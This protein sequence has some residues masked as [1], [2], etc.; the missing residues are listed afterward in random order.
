M[1]D[2]VNE[3][4][5]KNS[6]DIKRS[7]LN[8]VEKDDV[9]SL[10]E[11]LKLSADVNVANFQGRTPLFYANSPE[12]AELLIEAGADVTDQAHNMIVRAI[13]GDHKLE[14]TDVDAISASRDAVV[15]TLVVYNRYIGIGES[16]HQT[17]FCSSIEPDVIELHTQFESLSGLDKSIHVLVVEDHFTNHQMSILM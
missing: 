15:R 17:Y 9:A 6:E 14:W 16:S 8:A 1:A 4:F 5:N 13:L 11:I 3:K 12:V 2:S 10:K 7:L